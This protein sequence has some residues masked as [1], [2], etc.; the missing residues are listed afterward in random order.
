MLVM[1]DIHEINEISCVVLNYSE[2]YGRLTIS[3]I[4][5]K[6]Y[7]HAQYMWTMFSITSTKILSITIRVYHEG[8]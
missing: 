7:I 3:M 6:M 5:Y 8:K 1:E 2:D 4:N